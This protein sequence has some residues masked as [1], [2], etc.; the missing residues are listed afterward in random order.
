MKVNTLMMYNDFV[1]DIIDIRKSLN[2]QKEEYINTKNYLFSKIEQYKHYIDNFTNINYEEISNLDRLISEKSLIHLAEIQGVSIDIIRRTINMIVTINKQL[3]QIDQELISLKENQ[4]HEK[5]FINFLYKFNE[6]VSDKIVYKGY[7][8]KLGS[9]L[10]H[11]RIKKVDTVHN[12]NGTLKT[13]KRI[14]WNESNKKK[15]EILNKGGIPFKVLTRDEKGKPLTDNGGEEWFI[16]HN[17]IFDYL[18][19]WNKNRCLVL[20]SPYYKFTPTR[21]NNTDKNPNNIRVGNVNKLKKLV[22]TNDPLL[23]NFHETVN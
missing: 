21:Y 5:D 2:N 18:W 3:Y 14:N 13:K 12:K 9:G 8:L 20:N 16:Y 22:T 6:K 19:H 4:V 7:V 23:R 1:S 17:N 15:A 10:G 11:I